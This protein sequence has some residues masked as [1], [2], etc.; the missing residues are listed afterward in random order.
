VRLAHWVFGL[1][2]IAACGVGTVW[3][4]TP[5]EADRLRE[6]NEA[7]ARQKFELQQAIERLTAQTRLADVYVLDQSP[8]RSRPTTTLQFVEWDRQGRPLP[9]RCFTVEDD[10]IFFDALVIKFDNQRVAAGDALRGK[11]LALFRR[12]F[13]EHQNPFDGQRI[14]PTREVPKIFRG[15]HHANPF[16]QQL[17]SQFWDYVEKP[18]L[19]IREGVRVAQGEA[20]YVRMRKGQQW[21]LA[22]DSNG[23]LNI[24]LIRNPA[25]GDSSTPSASA[26][27]SGAL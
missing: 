14:D 19:A 13:G 1:A 4:L 5:G 24:K 3:L 11:S 25:E 27:P 9:A 18:D 12:V 16:E 10:V 21:T 22:L 7:L 20:V 2:V 15:E 26:A 23:G 17:W 6:K 8:G